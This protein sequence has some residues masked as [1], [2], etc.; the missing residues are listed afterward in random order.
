MIRFQSKIDFENIRKIGFYD[1]TRSRIDYLDYV[2]S[3]TDFGY[4][5]QIQ[6]ITERKKAEESFKAGEKKYRSIGELIPFGVWTTDA[7]GQAT[8]ISQSFC[9]LVGRTMEDIIKFGWID[10]LHPD[11]QE[12]TVKDWMKNVEEYGFW[13]YTHR[14]MG[15]DG[16]YHHI[17][18]RGVPLK[19]SNG[20]L[21]GWAGLNI[22]S[23]QR[24][25]A[26]V[27]IQRNVKLLNGIN[28][29]FSESLTCET[30]EDV[31]GK[32]LEVAEELTGSEFSFIG[33]I[34]ENGHLDDRAISPPEWEACTANPEKSFELLTDMEIVS[35]RG[36][37]IKE[38]KSQTRISTSV[39]G[40]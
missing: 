2:I 37:T 7:Q 30:V 25:Q 34:N 15:I 11:D 1:H 33:E 3:V 22:D 40:R 21:T 20:K 32:C 31:V 39:Q 23:T 12:C 18:A 4:L 16:E 17:L 8:Y 28:K 24:K 13:D 26:E 29:V 5:V 38:E 9:D 10:T 14:V 19:D 27:E 6:D 36:R 35:Y